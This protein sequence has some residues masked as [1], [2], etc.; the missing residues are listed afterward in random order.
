MIP[1]SIELKGFLSF[2]EEQRLEFEKDQVWL[3][4]GPNGS[5]KSTV[6]DAILFA[7]Y[8]GH[9]AGKS[10]LH[11]LI[12]KDSNRAL[13]RFD[14]ALAGQRYRAERT[15]E[16][17][18]DRKTGRP[19]YASTQQ[20]CAWHDGAESWQPIP[21]THRQGDFHEWVREHVGLSFDAFTSSAL[22]MQGRAD[23]L[24]AQDAEAA[25]R[26]F[27]V[28]HASSASITTRGCTSRR[29]SCARKTRSVPANCRPSST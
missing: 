10:D 4:S 16:R 24:V 29:T 5:G 9:R 14:F 7:L 26:R 21:G 1:V 18:T 19:G 6:F 22:L 15:V 8:A 11:E 28:P 17:T 12:N 25:R 20:L 27:E 3:L 23:V 2:R 13:V